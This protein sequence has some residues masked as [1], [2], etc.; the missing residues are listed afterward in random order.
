MRWLAE[1][2]LLLNL[3]TTTVFATAVFEQK[4]P[5]GVIGWMHTQFPEEAVAIDSSEAIEGQCSIRMSTDRDSAG[6]AW[7]VSE[8]IEVPKSGRLGVSLA[9]RAAAKLDT[10]SNQLARG[11]THKIRISIE[12]NREEEAV[13][14][15][16]QIDVPCDGQWQGRRLVLE[17]D[18]LD[19]Y[20]MDSVR[21]TI[22][23]LSQGKVWIDDVH[24][25]DE[26]P[27]Q[28]ERDGD[29]RFCVSRDPRTAE[30]KPEGSRRI[31]AK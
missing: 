19:R 7:L 14:F 27:T 3:E 5:V 6:R 29:P 1:S 18:G 12:G 10:A 13:R 11:S 16:A 21:L 23:S 24:L 30:G 2:G 28:L 25:H 31:A 17:A 22:D 4:G 26:F 8:P 20:K 9:A 15:S